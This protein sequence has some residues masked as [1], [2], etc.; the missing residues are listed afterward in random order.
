MTKKDA[1]HQ[2]PPET[3]G[4]EMGSSHIYFVV[5]DYSTTGRTTGGRQSVQMEGS[6]KTCRRKVGDRS[7]MGSNLCAM[8]GD[9]RM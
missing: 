2:R 3:I 6:A 9:N 5:S 7:P 8:V 1:D 4:E